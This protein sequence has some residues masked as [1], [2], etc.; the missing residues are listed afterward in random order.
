MCT[1]KERDHRHHYKDATSTHGMDSSVCGAVGLKI[2]Q[3][4]IKVMVN[5][6]GSKVC[7]RVGSFGSKYCLQAILVNL[8]QVISIFMKDKRIYFG[9]C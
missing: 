9:S 8:W 6:Q 1:C 5:S 2:N 7:S 4:S 3:I